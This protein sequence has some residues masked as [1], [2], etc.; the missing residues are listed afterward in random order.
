MTIKE[1]LENAEKLEKDNRMIFDVCLHMTAHPGMKKL[2]QSILEGKKDHV[3]EYEEL[4]RDGNP[5]EDRFSPVS[6]GAFDFSVY[7]QPFGFDAC[8]EYTA[9]LELIVE[10]KRL[11]ANLYEF[12]AVHAR[13]DSD[14]SLFQSLSDE[15][16]KHMSWVQDRLDLETM[17]SSN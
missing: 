6:Q 15:E 10:R 14:R 3:K 1:L 17:L 4:L 2:I 8:V 12:I 13:S 9:Y 11:L 7:D 16:K 5:L